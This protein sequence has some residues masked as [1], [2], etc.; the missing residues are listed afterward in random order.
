MEVTEPDPKNLHVSNEPLGFK[1]IGHTLFGYTAEVKFP[2]LEKHFEDYSGNQVEFDS[3]VD[4]KMVEMNF[5]S[6]EEMIKWYWSF[7]R[8]INCS[9]EDYEI[10]KTGEKNER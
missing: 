8:Y 10:L 5:E 7:G 4:Y 6:Q 1:I 2:I 3:I 9:K